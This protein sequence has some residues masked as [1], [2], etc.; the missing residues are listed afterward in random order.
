MLLILD[1]C[2]LTFVSATD[3]MQTS[4]SAKLPKIFR[5]IVH[6]TLKF[7]S[8]TFVPF[9]DVLDLKLGEGPRASSVQKG[10]RDGKHIG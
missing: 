10:S 7:D 8:D 3:L 5:S 2:V 6:D 1:T 4:N 9:S